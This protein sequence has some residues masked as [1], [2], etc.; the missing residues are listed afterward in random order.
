MGYVEWVEC[1]ETIID[2]LVA[3]GDSLTD[4]ALH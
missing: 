4:P 1:S 2:E 3:N